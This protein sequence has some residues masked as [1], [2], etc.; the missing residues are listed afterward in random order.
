[1][2]NLLLAVALALGLGFAATGAQ[3]ATIGSNVSALQS[4]AKAGNSLVEKTYYRRGHWR[5]R[6]YSRHRYYRPWRYRSH[7]YYG[8]R[9]H[10][11]RPYYRHHRR[12]R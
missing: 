3:A 11:Y 12:W 2:R 8:W 6:Y 4:T 5:H 10:H 9:H 1:M 7:R